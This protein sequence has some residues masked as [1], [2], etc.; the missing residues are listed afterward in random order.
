MLRTLVLALSLI[1]VVPFAAAKNVIPRV[2]RHQRVLQKVLTNLGK[3]MLVQTLNGPLE[4]QLSPH[5]QDAMR[6][7]S[8]WGGHSLVRYDD[9]RSITI[10]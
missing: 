3:K 2:H 10:R 6:L 4:G 9:V 8:V 5:S 7:D 1:V